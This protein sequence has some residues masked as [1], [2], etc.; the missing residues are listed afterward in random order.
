M[1]EF[2]SAKHQTLR[3][4]FGTTHEDVW[5]VLLKTVELTPPLSEDRGLITKR[6]ANPV[7]SLYVM[8]CAFP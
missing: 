1:W 2:D 3:E 8:R 6:L 5:K 7:S 4:I